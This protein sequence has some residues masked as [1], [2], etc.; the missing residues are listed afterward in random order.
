MKKNTGKTKG[1]SKKIAKP[2]PTPEKQ[3]Q[4]RAK[5]DEFVNVLIPEVKKFLREQGRPLQ[6]HEGVKNVD[7]FDYYRH[8]GKGQTFKSFQ[9][10]RKEGFNVKKGEK[11]LLCYGAKV[12]KEKEP[13][14]DSQEENKKYAFFPI[15]YVF[16]EQQ[17][18]PITFLTKVWQEESEKMQ[19]FFNELENEKK[20][21]TEK[22]L[23]QT[24]SKLNAAYA[25]KN[26]ELAY[27]LLNISNELRQELGIEKLTLPSLESKFKDV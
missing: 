9:N 24:S 3:A 17:V 7:I 6:L 4:K 14:P 11:G 18:E 5:I 13:T 10:W 23:N 19:H 8:T 25:E 2:Q 21:A 16:S 27:T 20:K 22:L 26:Y 1:N 15:G 12:E